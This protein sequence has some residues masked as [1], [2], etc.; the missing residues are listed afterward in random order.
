MFAPFQGYIP[1]YTDVTV[2]SFRR[3]PTSF[4]QRLLNI[5]NNADMFKFDRL[6]RRGLHGN[7]GQFRWMRI[8]PCAAQI[9]QTNQK[10]WKNCWLHVLYLRRCHVTGPTASVDVSQ[11]CDFCYTKLTLEIT[12]FFYTVGWNLLNTK[13][14]KKQNKLIA[15]DERMVT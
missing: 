13:R 5:T 15:F 3:L 11:N 14:N 9:T 8:N 10:L 6:T 2:W 1:L 7:Y 12:Q 4:C